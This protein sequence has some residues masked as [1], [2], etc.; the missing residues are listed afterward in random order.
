M[1]LGVIPPDVNRSGHR[2]T[3]KDQSTITYGLGAIKGVGQSAIDGIVM[4]REAGGPFRD[5]GDFCQRVDLQRV[6]KRVLEALVRAGA[7]DSVGANRATLMAQLPQAMQSAEQQSRNASLGQE[8]LFGGPRLTA[9]D[10]ARPTLPEWDEERRLQWEKEALGLYLTGHPIDRYRDEIEAI[11]GR[12]LNAWAELVETGPEG[13]NRFRREQEGCVG[14]LVVAVRTRNAP[15]G[16]E[17]FLTLDDRTGRIEVRVFPEEYARFANL[18]A[19]DRVLLIE[20][21]IG[22]DDYT[23][24]LR[25]RARNVLDID[26]ARQAHAKGLEIRLDANGA[27]N[28]FTKALQAVLEPFREGPTPIAI[29]YR[30]ATAMGRIRLGEHWQVQPTDELLHRLKELAGEDAVRVWY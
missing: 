10:V 9:T 28:G 30:N 29:T 8:D 12:S 5:I 27:A 16:R 18:I 11:A 2:F 4:A 25:M 24:G 7:L 14:G 1:G 17:A 26:Q 23:G 13:A 6:N 15:R 21:S 20:G 3:V 19:K 22:H